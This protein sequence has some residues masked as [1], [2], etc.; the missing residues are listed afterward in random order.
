[1]SLKGSI[2]ALGTC[3]RSRAAYARYHN[4]CTVILSGVV[5]R[6]ANDNAVEGP[7]AA[8]TTTN[9]KRAFSPH[10]PEFPSNPTVDQTTTG[11]FDSVR[12]S[13]L[14]SSHFRSG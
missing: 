11:S 9:V 6:G 8:S 2:A 1:M 10:W 12:T 7:L 14:R 4:P 13:L 5:V 3:W